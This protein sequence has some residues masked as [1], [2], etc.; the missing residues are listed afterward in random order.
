MEENAQE[1]TEPIKR[2]MTWVGYAT[3]LIGLG[4]SL[5]GGWHWY[6]GHRQEQAQLAAEMAV[7]Q[8]QAKQGEYDAAIR[9]Y[10][11]ILKERPLYAPALKQQA[12]AAMTWV[13]N[14]DVS[15]DDQAGIARA[16]APM[17]D[18]ITAVLDGAL[19]RSKGPEAADVQAHL[20][21]AHWLN[22]QVARRESGSAAEQDFRAALATDPSNVYGHAMLADWLLYNSIDVDEA[23][24]HFHTALA[25]G[26][27]RPFIR[28]LEIKGLGNGR[29]LKGTRADLSRL[30]SE[31]R[32]NG[33][34]L[35][36]ERKES[37]LSFCCNPP[38]TPLEDFHEFLSAV[39][40]DEARLTYLWLDDEQ[41]D[42][43]VAL[44]Q[45]T[46]RAYVDANLLEIAGKR[47]EAL[48]KYRA[49]QKEIQ[50]QSLSLEDD[51]DAAVKRLS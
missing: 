43:R 31:M 39:P 25:T 17:L 18:A 1:K 11:A 21:W 36:E 9:S 7:A 38:Y 45:R 20:G 28:T 8:T 51:V 49:I 46:K 40:T 12:D 42:D 13:E 30:L 41:Y 6:A 33:E 4:G 29:G 16:A 50:G 19:A 15:G 32:K 34:P 26:K 27:A 47:A 2:A 48:D 14:F 22:Q 24:G 5:V 10:D 44:G 23:I 35:R 37:I 3:A